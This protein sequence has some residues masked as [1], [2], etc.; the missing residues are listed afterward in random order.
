MEKSFSPK[1]KKNIENTFE[2]MNEFNRVEIKT[3]WFI[4]FM[5]RKKLSSNGKLSKLRL[6]LVVVCGNSPFLTFC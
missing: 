4:Y 1:R 3:F 6:E 2:M 5:T